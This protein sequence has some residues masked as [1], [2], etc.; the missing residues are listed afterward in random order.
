MYAMHH[1]ATN[2]ISDI[3]LLS[4]FTSLTYLNLWSNQISDIFPLV[5]NEGLSVGDFVDLCLNPLDCEAYIIFIPQL[6]GRGVTVYY[7]TP[8]Y[9]IDAIVDFDPD[10]LNLR[11]KG[12]FVMV[13]IQLPLG[14]EVSQ[15]DAVTIKLNGIVAALT[16]PTEIGDYN[17]DG[18][19][20]MMVKFD[21]AVVH[22]IINIDELV[23][24]II[25]G[26]LNGIC[27][28]GSDTIRV[29]E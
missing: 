16:T 5:D 29:I 19:D 6:E 14:Y 28:K 24:V 13:Y 8:P 1:L 10:T 3:S 25:T 2:Y 15:I 22:S 4:N 21:R 20:D 27:F 11:S 12:K 7:D 23:E 18:I 17:N 26:G 9:T